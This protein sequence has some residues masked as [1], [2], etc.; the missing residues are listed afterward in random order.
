[1]KKKD[2][3]RRALLPNPR[4]LFLDEPFEASTR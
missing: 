3:A 1:M 4:A 2:C